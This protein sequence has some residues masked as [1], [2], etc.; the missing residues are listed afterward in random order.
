[1]SP[2][3]LPSLHLHPLPLST[4]WSTPWHHQKTFTQVTRYGLK[5][6]RSPHFFALSP[7]FYTFYLNTE[8]F[9]WSFDH[10]IMPAWS[11][12]PDCLA[13]LPCLFIVI[14]HAHVHAVASFFRWTGPTST[15]NVAVEQ[16]LMVDDHVFHLELQSL[17]NYC[18]KAVFQS[19]FQ[20]SNW[21]QDWKLFDNSTLLI[22][23]TFWLLLW[24]G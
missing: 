5:I 22:L 21:N 7:F 23:M 6:T 24:S 14:V 4:L 13:L 19:S 1:M 8:L 17:Q 12:L 20:F 3:P 18:F 9:N 16:C 10:I 11:C 2:L 15:R